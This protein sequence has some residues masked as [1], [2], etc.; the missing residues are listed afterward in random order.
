MKKQRS[1]TF[2]LMLLVMLPGFAF[3]SP[4]G[5]V[6][7]NSIEPNWF[8]DNKS[9]WYRNDL[10][11]GKR[12]FVVVNADKGVRKPAFDHDRLAQAL[13]KAGLT[14]WTRHHGMSSGWDTRWESIIR[15]TRTLTTRTS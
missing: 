8:D 6:C 15:R 3:N 5:R 1:L 13:T 10:A 14:E 9:F 2:S 11:D 7:K 12:E 4:A